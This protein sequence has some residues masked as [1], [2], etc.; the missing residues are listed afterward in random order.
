M[1]PQKLVIALLA[2]LAAPAPAA[3]FNVS[4]TT[5]GGPGSLR[6]AIS[7]ANVNEEADEILVPAGTYTLTIPGRSE[8]RNTSGDLD[9]TSGSVTIRG[10]GAAQTII[11]G[12]GLD[13][14]FHV[15]GQGQLI[16]EGVTVTGGRAADG[17]D[18]TGEAGGDG[19]NGGGILAE[20]GT[21]IIDCVIRGNRAGAGGTGFQFGGSGG[22]GGGIFS[23][24]FQFDTFSL[25]SDEGTETS[26]EG[27]A[28][29]GTNQ[30]SMPG[31]LE[32]FGSTVVNNHSGDGGVAV[33]GRG[34]AGGGGGGIFAGGFCV[35]VTTTIRDNSAGAA[36]GVSFG[37][38]QPLP[39][40]DG[41]GIYAAEGLSLRDCT[42][43]GNVAGF[44]GTS[45]NN[46][47]GGRG[48]GGGGI[49]LTQSGLDVIQST[50]SGNRSGDGGTGSGTA[51]DGAAGSGG[52]IFVPNET[53]GQL[54]NATVA[55][56]RAGSGSDATART[57]G[58]GGGL[59][60][61]F[62][63]FYIANS[64][65]AQ[66]VGR[67][68]PD[69]SG[70]VNSGGSNLIGDGDGSDGFH[71]GDQVGSG[72]DG[73]VID[74]LI[75]PLADNGGF[76]QT[77][78][79][80][81]AS[82]AIDTGNNGNAI[83]YSLANDQRGP[84]FP[85]ILDGDGNG[86]SEV[87]IGAFEAPGA[88]I[89]VTT[90]ADEDDGS[91]N[92]QLGSGT[93]LREAMHAVNAGA[94]S[95]ITFAVGGTIAPTFELP[96]MGVAFHLDG[97]TAP[98]YQ[99]GEPPVVGIDGSDASS[100][101]SGI[102]LGPNSDGSVITAFAVRNFSLNGILVSN[103]SGN[104]I[105]GCAVGIAGVGVLLSGD[106]N[107]NLVGGEGEGQGNT[108]A[109]STGA[110]VVVDGEGASG[111][112]VLRNS[113]FDNAGGGISL[114]PGANGSVAP[115]AI[116]TFT[117]SRAAGTAE[118]GARV[119][120]FYD[121]ATL[122]AVQGDEFVAA[123]VAD[124][125]GEWEFEGGLDTGR[126]LAATQTTTADNTSEFAGALTTALQVSVEQGLGQADPTS[127]EPIVFRATFSEPVAP[128]SFTAEDVALGGTALPETAAIF[129][130]SSGDGTDFDI[131]V[132]GMAASGTFTASI[133]M[134]AVMN[135]S[136]TVNDQSV[137]EDNTVTYNFTPALVLS[138][139]PT[140]IPES[141]GATTGSLSRNGSLAEDL[142]VSLAS[143][144]T[145]E[146]TVPA[147]VTIP[148]GSAAAPVTVTAVDDSER[149]GD[150]IVTITANADGFPAATASI[151]VI[152]DDPTTFS[153]NDVTMLEGSGGGTTTFTFTVTRDANVGDETIEVFTQDGSATA[154]EDYAPIGEFTINFPAEGTLTMAVDVSVVADDTTEPD[155][156]FTVNLAAASQGV[157][158]ADNQGVGTIL[159]DDLPAVG[160][161]ATGPTATEE[162][163]TVGSYT[164]TREGTFGDLVVHLAFDPASTASA[165]DWFV[166]TAAVFEGSSGTITIA[167]GDN[168]TE[169]SI[170]AEDDIAAEPD[171]TVVIS[172]AADA[173]YT[174]GENSSATVTIPQNDTVVT[175]TDDAG[176]G[177]LRQAILNAEALPGP[178][179][180]TFDS[181]GANGTILLE[182][183]LP[184]LTTEIEILN[185][186]PGSAP[187]EVRRS[188]ES[189]FGIFSVGE[190][191]VVTLAGLTVAGGSGGGE[192][193]GGGIINA[194][195]LEVRASLVNGNDANNGGGIFNTGILTVT[196]TTLSGNMAGGAGGGIANFGGFADISFATITGNVT[197][198]FAGGGVASSDEEGTQTVVSHSIIAGNFD[199]ESES[200]VEITVVTELPLDPY[201]SAG[202][203][204]IG[205]GNGTNA[206]TE[207]GDQTGVDDPGLGMLADNG[208]LSFTH[209]LLPTSP[210]VDAGDPEIAM[211]P[212]NDQRGAG[213]PRLDG[214]AVDMGAFELGVGSVVIDLVSGVASAT[215]TVSRDHLTVSTDGLELVI[216]T[217]GAAVLSTNTPADVQI[218]QDGREARIALQDIVGGL[219]IAAGE[220]DDSLELDFANGSPIPGG[221]ILFDG[222]NGADAISMG[223]ATVGTVT[224][225]FANESD[226]QI[227]IDGQSLA[228]LGLAPVF[229]NL[230]AAD[231][232]FLFTGGDET[233]T[234]SEADGGNLIDSTQ[235][236]S[237]FFQSPSNSMTVDAGS[238]QDEVVL[239][240]LAPSFPASLTVVSELIT[241]G[242]TSVVTGGPQSYDAPQT[243]LDVV[244]IEAP[245]VIFAGSVDSVTGG[246]GALMADGTVEFRDE[247]G[248]AEPLALVD[249]S[250]GTAILSGDVT[251]S[252]PQSYAFVFLDADVTLTSDDAIVLGPVEGSQ[253][254]AISGSGTARLDGS[255]GAVTQLD[256][257]TSDAGGAVHL[258][259]AG[260]STTGNQVFGNP[261]VVLASSGG[262]KRLQGA[263]VIFDPVTSGLELQG[264]PFV[265]E[266]TGNASSVNAISG[267]GLLRKLGPGTL[268]SGGGS[269]SG[270][271]SVEAGTLIA[272]GDIEGS[273]HTVGAGAILTGSGRLGSIE[274]MAGA[275]VIP[276]AGGPDARM[277]VGGPVTL[278]AGSTLETRI[279]GTA[280]GDTVYE[281]GALV[282]DGP[283]SLGGADL[284]VVLVGGFDAAAGDSFPVVQSSGAAPVTGTFAGLPEGGTVTV[285]SDT[286]QITYQGGDGNDV[287]LQ[288]VEPVV[289]FAQA[290]YSAPEGDIEV[291]LTRDITTAGDSVV[292]I[293]PAAGTATAGADFSAAPID[294]FFANG[295]ASE[296]VTIPVV[297]DNVVELDET[298]TLT[299]TATTNSGI[300]EIATAELTILND[301]S[302]TLSIGGLTEDEG[303]GGSRTI[304]LP[305]TLSA[306]VDIAVSVDATT[307]PGTATA[308]E[309]YQAAT[310]PLTFAAGA[311]G[312]MNVP[313]TVIGDLVVE[314][315][316]SFF[317]NLG[318][319][320]SGGR[321][322]TIA[323]AQG[324]VGLRNDDAFTL[325]IADASAAESS[326]TLAFTVTLDRAVD[327][328]VTVD[329]STNDDTATAGSDYTATSG[330]LTFAG[331]ANETRT[332][333]V[334]ILNDG[335]VE[336]DE[337]FFV[338]LNNLGS[339]G[340]SG[341]I[342]DSRGVGTI[343]NDDSLT[344]AIAATDPIATEPEVDPATDTGTFRISHNAPAG[345]SEIVIPIDRAASTAGVSD[346]T[347]SGGGVSFSG[348]TGS[349]TVPA[350]QTFVDVTVIALADIPAE[351]DETVVFQLQDAGSAT[352]TI[353]QN[354]FVVT[355][356]GSPTPSDPASAEGTLAQALANVSALGGSPTVTFDM[357]PGSPFA[358]D[359]PDTIAMDLEPSSVVVSQPGTIA[360][361]GADR[362]TIAWNPLDGVSRVPISADPGDGEELVFSGLTF[363]G[364][365]GARGGVFE[366]ASG[367]LVLDGCVLTGNSCEPRTGGGAPIPALGGGA[368]YVQNGALVAR[369]S[370]I[371]N[372]TST[373]DGGGIFVENGAASL[374]NSTV[375]GNAAAGSGGGIFASEG[376][377]VSLTNVTLTDNTVALDGG[378]IF[379]DGSVTVGNSILAANSAGASPD[380]SGAFTSLGSNLVGNGAGGT[381]IA[382]GATGDQVGSA[383]APID[384]RLA[385]LADNGGPS[386][387]HLP[388]NRSASDRSPAVDAGDNA[389]AVA[390]SLAGDQRG[391]ARIY[392]P[393]IGTVDIGAVEVQNALPVV[394]DASLLDQE[395]DEDDAPTTFSV[396]GAFDDFEDGG[397]GLSYEV[398]ANSNPVLV[399][400]EVVAGTD[401]RLTFGRDRTG[402]AEIT[403]R[404]TD[405]Q[406]SFVD[407]TFVVNVSG[408][409][410]VFVDVEPVFSPVVA[411]FGPHE[412]FRV[413]VTNTGPS[414]FF[415]LELADDTSQFP[416]GPQVAGGRM[417]S[418]S[419]GDGV[420]SI[421][422]LPEGTTTQLI[423]A[424]QVSADVVSG[425]LTFGM[426][427][428]DP[429]G[430]IGGTLFD[431]ATVDVINRRDL[432]VSAAGP[433]T[434]AA[435]TGHFEQE[436][437]IS[438][439]TGTTIPS[440]RLF[441]SPSAGDIVH[442]NADGRS[443]RY[444]F[445]EIGSPLA[446]GADLLVNV[447]FS[448]AN[449]DP[450]FGVA[451]HVIPIAP[452]TPAGDP[453][454]P[455]PAP[456]PAASQFAVGDEIPVDLCAMLP[457][458]TFLLGWPSEPGATYT[459]CFAGESFSFQDVSTSVRAIS[460]RALWVDDGAETP[461]RPSA[462][463]LR[464]YKVR[465]SAEPQ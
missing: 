225:T 144:D 233:I 451:Y 300:G 148:A 194:G 267:S 285:G 444:S 13:R 321:A 281:T 364:G 34:G 309:D 137:S 397:S 246:T 66:N 10:A 132:S 326:G 425:G 206:F 339:S 113:M 289:E 94:T 383:G 399:V 463:P 257:F 417:G 372:N 352:V 452:P 204:L 70:S 410:G 199:S 279:S 371:A 79:L 263:D 61:P 380:V 24:G 264:D 376:T 231:R 259:S 119:E 40:G 333:N 373:V 82:P 120:L 37:Q 96:L 121:R 139:D 248:G 273:A 200:D 304:F 69:V 193:D 226:G 88:P 331:N 125:A 462:A 176:E 366:V 455:N 153:I 354:D 117:A 286:F 112:R 48:G 284:N 167:D 261:V 183:P 349:V 166:L 384:P 64:L 100:V 155:E 126:R 75:G 89:T 47:A 294:V 303:N 157:A 387:T 235:G 344:F 150:Q 282:A 270:T 269:F 238:G 389:L 107:N 129:D 229:D 382:D 272:D 430:A 335:N 341:S 448:R 346:Y 52:G 413:S 135:A 215:G 429:S 292:R 234:I 14:V 41:G 182:S 50:I 191:G 412:L 245:Q 434:F 208:G 133:P 221:G 441:V 203:N 26:G 16:L 464:F 390:A 45:T 39:G 419:Y 108:I 162:Q 146:A 35:M 165:S 23:P 394:A 209:A 202:F 311:T 328:P 316:E 77:H 242:A 63:S 396:A 104:V 84:G 253:S 420:W 442:E 38:F 168:S 318:N 392:P 174:V 78:A 1:N 317:V 49:F 109:S 378:G 180:I 122:P 310:V 19:E 18:S 83:E 218:L 276:G 307:A 164:I 27:G 67:V 201:V 385:P 266:V 7:A 288:V 398:T 205:F 118:A 123:V 241:V 395:A 291:T 12:G 359:V 21:T 160:I 287:V 134:G 124:G 224:H 449:G 158:F 33:D 195:T 142:A 465:K 458:G 324:V 428:L 457:D 416:A 322:V 274:A 357:S 219:A 312:V 136:G 59:A 99:P 381:G 268:T 31:Q 361:P 330:S 454:S 28:E 332:I 415:D 22:R 265:I 338:D 375:S 185:D 207:P 188:S 127:T 254:L 334:T 4:T 98:G 302:A 237:V 93:S 223:G 351:A 111:N 342:A 156:T 91:P 255:V 295:S 159:N 421:P 184:G 11:D 275:T 323:V 239:H 277:F 363:T 25:D 355:N 103:S 236:E 244:T 147:A 230:D 65:V 196:N 32:L 145:S 280:Q 8:D 327:A 305:V 161:V 74:P 403:L 325:T 435:A 360:G 447:Q 313:V 154:G 271:T 95:T 250:N 402:T 431:S 411:G 358:D 432:P 306:P 20:G 106:S 308:P 54:V 3:V 240:G 151:T 198:D 278:D 426:G 298:F 186:L 81:P 57:V 131:F 115:P 163:D 179:T 348:D 138:F 101:A 30:V 336:P 388:R 217:T 173:S 414:D 62:T 418:G 178:D 460:F 422:V 446:P 140:A 296:T 301:D 445:I 260:I 58:I 440:L 459:V 152:D 297:S 386:P 368:I 374:S 46:G 102:V 214:A 172:I 319:L 56:N 141:G 44:G 329:F 340:R 438:N 197:G 9:I 92:P 293:T 365:L 249:V 409:F 370:T 379:S 90:L 283:V 116:D 243:V 60:S 393:G 252:G 213:F 423:V 347:L 187:V 427:V 408:A 443:G 175:N 256:S 181:P 29:P 43:S 456:G 143:D 17:T 130:A 404:A 356:L 169:F 320:A 232:L 350:G 436:V 71:E 85:R 114:A 315:D 353:P 369:N 222:Q 212:A 55:S 406:G 42:I 36:S 405:A 171:E 210:A 192:I 190:T 5:D 400:A 401:V 450:N 97:T 391:F 345:S 170:L 220:G 51:P 80:L 110:G 86:E 228:Y 149:D 437:T 337:T 128:G 407:A 6:A 258:N 73:G 15:G 216:V 87:D 299:L 461:S 314:L 262:S 247:V 76:T 251:T 2:L 177:S 290:T 105:Q 377:A 367:T 424:I 433:P 189:P 72:S 343:L 227:D 53:F 68:A 453:A 362:L 211:P 439:N